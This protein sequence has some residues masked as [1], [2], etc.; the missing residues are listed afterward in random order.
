LAGAV[1]VLGASA[2]F[3]EGGGAGKP[4][5]V[6]GSGVGG[7]VGSDFPVESPS[8]LLGHG[9]NREIVG[10]VHAAAPLSDVILGNRLRPGRDLRQAWAGGLLSGRWPRGSHPDVGNAGAEV[11]VG[12]FL[13]VRFQFECFIS[14]VVGKLKVD[15]ND[16]VVSTKKIVE[17]W[18]PMNNPF[19]RKQAVYALEFLEEARIS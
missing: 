17:P 7:S 8:E 14:D 2:G 5:S 12:V 6:F 15:R 11:V 3:T 16:R 13:E 1:V 10:A 9:G 18:V 19:F 4:I